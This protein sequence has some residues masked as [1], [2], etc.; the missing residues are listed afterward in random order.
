L[1]TTGWKAYVRA[2]LLAAMTLSAGCGALSQPLHDLT[3]PF[4]P[5]ARDEAIR[6][7]AEADS[8][9]DAKRAGL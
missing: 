8:F 6:Q 3:H 5:S 4:G 7:Q 9:P 2:G 1:S